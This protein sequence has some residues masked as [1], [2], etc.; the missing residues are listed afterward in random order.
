MKV[1][2]GF[3]L[4]LMYIMFGI[5]MIYIIIGCN[6]IL[7]IGRSTLNIGRAYAGVATNV[8]P[9]HAVASILV[10]FAAGTSKDTR[11]ILEQTIEDVTVGDE[12][13]YLDLGEP[14]AGASPQHFIVDLDGF[15]IIAVDYG[16]DAASLKI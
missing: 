16:T 7:Q 5:S 12:S 4:D 3:R 10:R 6:I 9:S 11:D 2:A 14:D 8:V 13:V 15:D 1:C